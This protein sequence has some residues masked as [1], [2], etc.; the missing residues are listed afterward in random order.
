MSQTPALDYS[1]NFC[2][3]SP[4]FPQPWASRCFF[5]QWSHAPTKP[6]IYKML[7]TYTPQKTIETTSAFW[8]PQQ[9]NLCY[10]CLGFVH[11]Y[12]APNPAS[13][14]NSSTPVD[15]EANLWKKHALSE[16][17]S[18]DI[19]TLLPRPSAR[20]N[21]QWQSRRKP[22]DICKCHIILV[23]AIDVEKKTNSHKT[24]QLLPKE[25]SQTPAKNK[26]GS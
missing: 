18:S 24:W 16:L 9:S 22:T 23:L 11:Y 17:S 6:I 13:A 14:S 15:T 8:Y 26:A 25:L 1:P 12:S 10:F 2:N 3:L 5:R 21:H 7:P 20:I 19:I 4:R